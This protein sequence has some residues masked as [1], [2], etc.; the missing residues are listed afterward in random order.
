M[1]NP[2]SMTA[3]HARTVSAALHIHTAYSACS[4][5]G[6]EEIIAYCRKWKVDV[7]GITDHDTIDG[8]LALKSIAHDIRIII[9]E[10][11]KTRHGEIV[12]LFLKEKV[13][14]NLDAA[15]TCRRIKDQGGLVYLPHPFDP[16]KIHRLK[17]RVLDE[18][19]DMVDIIEVFNAKTLFPMFNAVA[20]RFAERHGKVAAVGS[21]AHYLDAIDLCINEM[22]DFETPEQFLESLRDANL[23]TRRSGPYRQWWVGIKNVLRGEGHGMRKFGNRW[24]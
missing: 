17:K 15:E 10:E 14:P 3:A 24:R 12:G 22:S 19:L 11:I 23:V 2:K 5:S 4:E 1:S 13:E 7:L 20:A 18:I 16:F 9:G 21:D 8:A 6:L